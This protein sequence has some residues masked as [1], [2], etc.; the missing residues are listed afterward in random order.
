[1]ALFSQPGGR[2]TGRFGTFEREAEARRKAGIAIA[3]GQD[4]GQAPEFSL[5]RV[6]ALSQEQMSPQIS[7]VRRAIQGVQAGRFANP[8]ARREAIRGAVRGGGEALAGIQAAGTR[9]GLALHRT[10]FDAQMAE[11]RRQEEER[12]REEQRQTFRRRDLGSSTYLPPGMP[13]SGGR[14]SPFTGFAPAPAPTMPIRLPGGSVSNRLLEGTS[15]ATAGGGGKQLGDI[16]FSFGS[17]PINVAPTFAPDDRQHELLT[18]SFGR[19]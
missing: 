3:G 12:L 19:T 11:F 4:K 14:L 15:F 17:E 1:M 7:A 18:Q 9:Q 5:E 10:E 13:G 6:R 16:G 8:L 2:A